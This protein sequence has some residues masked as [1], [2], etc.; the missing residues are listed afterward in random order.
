MKSLLHVAAFAAAAALFSVAPIL[1]REGD[2]AQ[3]VRPAEPAKAEP[4]RQEQ[5]DPKWVET[6]QKL[7]KELTDDNAGLRAENQGLRADVEA[8][9]RELAAS[10][11]KLRQL[12]A[13]R[14]VL[15]IPPNAAQ[16]PNARQIPN[17]N[18]VPKN[19]QPFEFNGVTYYKI[20]L[21]DSKQESASGR[22]ARP[23]TSADGTIIVP[24]AKE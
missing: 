11:E 18:A 12:E 8:M 2:P 19:W 20:P 17:A 4:P 3:Q 16:V 21:A 7:L 6:M 5:K 14:G 23:A 24:R 10:S 1:A 15:V 22:Q 9:K 13:N